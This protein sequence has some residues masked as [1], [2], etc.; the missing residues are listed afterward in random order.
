MNIF[1]SINHP[2]HV[3]YFRNFIRLMEERGHHFIVTNRDSPMI[4]QL[5]DFYQIAHTTGRERKKNRSTL[6]VLYTLSKNVRN[7][8]RMSRRDHVDFYVGFGSASCALT[9]FVTRKPCVL[10]DDTD[11]NLK[12]QT[13]YLPFCSRV[14]TPFYFNS[15]LFKYKW[16]KRKQENLQ[17]YVEQFYLHSKYY[18]PDSSILDTLGLTSQDYVIVRFSAFDA[19]HDKGIQSL[20]VETRKSL[21]CLLEQKYRVVLSLEAPT[22]DAFFKE[23]LLTF[24]PHRMHDL[25]YHARMIV[26]EGATMASEA[27]VLGVPYLYLNP[28]KCGNINHQCSQSPE[29]ARQST[30]AKEVLTIVKELM[31]TAVDQQACRA[32]VEGSTICP[33]DYLTWF[34]ENYPSS[35][36]TIKKNSDYQ[37]RFR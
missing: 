23:R 4:N 34:V 31:E 8:V 20:D 2:A 26:T 13:I 1:I 19:S 14:F 3:H 16:A 18:H 30:D 29:R 12:N 36:R 17:A 25:L 35:K 5:L 21:I 24:P 10:V 32:E 15:K 7:M 37:L 28:I 22:D 33:T 27:Y 6:K 9:S 11:H